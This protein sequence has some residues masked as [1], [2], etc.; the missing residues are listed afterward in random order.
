MISEAAKKAV[1]EIIQDPL[2]IRE[3]ESAHLRWQPIIQSSIDAE[4]ADAVKRATDPIISLHLGQIEEFRAEI[5]RLKEQIENRSV[6]ES[7]L[8]IFKKLSR[9]EYEIAT[10][11]FCEDVCNAL[12]RG[13]AK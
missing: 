1:N 11:G 8:P 13:S 12:K 4:I 9:S 7:Y 10:S 5:A 2:V 6:L 3:R